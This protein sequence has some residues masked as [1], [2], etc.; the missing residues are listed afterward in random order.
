MELIPLIDHRFEPAWRY[1]AETH[2][3]QTQQTTV[4]APLNFDSFSHFA[5][6]IERVTGESWGTMGATV[7]RENCDN[8]FK[9][10]IR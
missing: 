6:A 5:V 2:E 9:S 8:V 10:V 7:D 3:P 4:I 1:V